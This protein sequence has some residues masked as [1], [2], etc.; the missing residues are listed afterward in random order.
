MLK[1]ILP[2]SNFI[3]I[4]IFNLVIQLKQIL[5]NPLGL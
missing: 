1:Y 5:L 4:V 3:F 2:N